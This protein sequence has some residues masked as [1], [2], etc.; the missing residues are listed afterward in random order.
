MYAS[1]SSCV[2][3]GDSEGARGFTHTPHVNLLKAVLLNLFNEARRKKPRPLSLCRRGINALPYYYDI[4]KLTRTFSWCV[5]TNPWNYFC[6]WLSLIGRRR[7]RPRRGRAY[8]KVSFTIS[9][10][11]N[12]KPSAVNPSVCGYMEFDFVVGQWPV[13]R[14]RLLSMDVDEYL[15]QYSAFPRSCGS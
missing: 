4:S 2:C 15:W 11:R 13:W 8:S 12:V 7:R 5:P 3:F 14:R 10:F 1:R 9:K 6:S